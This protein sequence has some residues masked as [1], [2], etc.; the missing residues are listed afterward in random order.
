MTRPDWDLYFIR[1]AMEVASRATCPRAAVGAVVVK[2]NRILSTGYNGAPAG[3]EHCTD[4]GCLME[5]EHCQRAVHAEFN[6][7]GFAAKYGISLDGA[8]MYV[9]DSMGRKSTPVCSKC[10]QLAKVAGIIRICERGL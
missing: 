2:G 1:I 7:L 8:T 6:A 3:E 5:N 9:C 10:S 4:V